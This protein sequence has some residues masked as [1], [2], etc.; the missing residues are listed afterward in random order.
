MKV[1][2]SL[3]CMLQ[4]G[5]AR[6]SEVV[7][8]PYRWLAALRYQYASTYLVYRSIVT[9]F[10]GLCWSKSRYSSCI[11]AAKLKLLP[12]PCTSSRCIQMAC[13]ASILNIYIPCS[14]FFTTVIFHGIGKAELSL[15]MGFPVHIRTF[16]STKCSCQIIKMEK[17]YLP[18][19]ESNPGLPRDRRGYLPLYYRG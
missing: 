11:Y 4:W 18:D 5:L 10:I 2:P 7:G 8:S 13:I 17:C 9:V 6:R 16:T 12:G 15:K 19:G 1:H 14:Q 3:H